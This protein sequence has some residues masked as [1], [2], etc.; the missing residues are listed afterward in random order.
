[1]HFPVA[2]IHMAILDHLEWRLTIVGYA[3]RRSTLPH[4][5]ALR[6][7][8]DYPALSCHECGLGR[9]LDS[10][11][12][13]FSERDEFKNLELSYQTLHAVREDLVKRIRAGAV[14]VEVAACVRQVHEA[15][16]QMLGYLTLLENV[17][18][19]TG[20]VDRS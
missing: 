8:A 13:S 9:W 18:L 15:S 3:L 14:P 1:V 17:E 4:D 16:M 2:L 19:A 11:G 12:Q 20:A 5:S 10:E 6:Q 7:T